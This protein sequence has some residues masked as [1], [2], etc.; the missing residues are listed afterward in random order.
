[1]DGRPDCLPA[2][3]FLYGNDGSPGSICL[4]GQIRNR[5]QRAGRI[6]YKVT[7]VALIFARHPRGGAE[8]L[9]WSV[10]TKTAKFFFR[11]GHI[12]YRELVWTKPRFGEGPTIRES[13]AYQ[14]VQKKSVFSTNFH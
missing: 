6:E 7:G 3:L 12:F 4:S 9:S 10:Q 8:I 11:V 1:M 13:V 14:T 2:V 5:N